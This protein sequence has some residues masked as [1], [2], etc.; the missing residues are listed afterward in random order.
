[1]ATASTNPPTE[2]LEGRVY[3]PPVP[4]GG[5][6]YQADGSA[7]IGGVLLIGGALLWGLSHPLQSQEL[8]WLGKVVTIIGAIVMLWD[9]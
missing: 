9:G 7:V 8:G 5:G 6:D 1:M 3:L 4:G 2:T